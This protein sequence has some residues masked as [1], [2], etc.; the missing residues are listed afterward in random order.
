MMCNIIFVNIFCR[1]FIKK[2]HQIEIPA[3]GSGSSVY[4]C[5]IRF[6]LLLQLFDLSCPLLFNLNSFAAVDSSAITK[7]KVIPQVM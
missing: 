6:T 7:R 2:L 4:F 5:F 3:K 1:A